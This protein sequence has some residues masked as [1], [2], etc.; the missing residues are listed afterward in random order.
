MSIYSNAFTELEKQYWQEI[1]QLQNESMRTGEDM[2][3]KYENARANYVIRKTQLEVVLLNEC[4][5]RR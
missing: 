3:E 4:Q 5:D 2:S 1:H